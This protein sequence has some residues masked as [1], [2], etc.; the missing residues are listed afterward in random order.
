MNKD[1]ETVDW[2]AFYSCSIV[3]EAW[4]LMKDIL[5]TSFK[6]HA[7]MIRK[8]VR[9]RPAPWLTSS[10]T[11]LMN[12][13]D[14]LLRKL[15]RTKSEL[16]ISKYRQIRNEVNIEI[17]KA[18]SSYHKNLLKENSTNPRQFWKTI[19][20]TYPTKSS[21]GSSTRSFDLLG[22]KITDTGKVA[23]GFCNFFT[24]IVKTL[25]EKAIPLCNVAWKPL[26]LYVKEPTISS[27]SGQY[28]R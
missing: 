27:V 6:N 10:V 16:D 20:S 23:N 1:L 2:S 4:S 22:E 12:G 28:Q 9:G 15:R 17:R 7:P 26:D 3:N 25:R 14:Q 19:K 21:T 8:K 24:T 18:E 11:K 5:L 13:R